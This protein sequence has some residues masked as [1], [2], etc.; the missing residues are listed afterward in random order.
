MA[1]LVLKTMK[2]GLDLSA[3][4]GT[5]EKIKSGELGRS[6]DILKK[7]MLEAVF[8]SAIWSIMSNCKQSP[9]LFQ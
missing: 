9:L 2:L 3:N 5:L 6:D 8:Q 4:V 1:R 7:A